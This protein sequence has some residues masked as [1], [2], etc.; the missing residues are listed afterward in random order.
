[1]D[2]PIRYNVKATGPVARHAAAQLERGDHVLVMGTVRHE[3]YRPQPDKPTD[4]VLWL[5]ADVIGKVVSIP[6]RPA[7]PTPQRL[8]LVRPTHRAA[9]NG[10]ARDRAIAPAA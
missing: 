1:T 10:P 9:P 8:T 4:T 5:V 3:R 6:P 2:E 7:P